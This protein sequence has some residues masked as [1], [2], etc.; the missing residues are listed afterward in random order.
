MGAM[1][2]FLGLF[3]VNAIGLSG[4]TFVVQLTYAALV[5]LAV[6]TPLI[7]IRALF[8]DHR[9][10][11]VALALVG[12]LFLVA[13]VFASSVGAAPITTFA[14]FPAALVLAVAAFGWWKWLAATRRRI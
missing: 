9:Y 10:A 4:A 6:A 1:M 12:A 3:G 5:G 13:G 14:V 7:G 2:A 11:R 8:G